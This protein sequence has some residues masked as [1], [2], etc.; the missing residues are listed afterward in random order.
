MKTHESISTVKLNTIFI[1]KNNI[2]FKL[3]FALA[4]VLAMAAS[5]NIFIYTAIS[6]VPITLQT[7]TVLLSGIFLG[8]RFA[9]MS[10]TA[11]LL[12]GI[13]GFPVFAGFRSGP[14]A[15]TGVTGGYLLGF[16]FAAYITGYIFENFENIVKE[17]TYLIIAACMS[18]LFIIYFLGY[19]HL[20]GLLYSGCRQAAFKT[21]AL[22]VFDIAVKPF[23]T[24][25]LIKLFIAVDSVLIWKANITK[26]VTKNH[27]KYIR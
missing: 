10:Q 5:A 19:V 7:I 6:P 23:V 18:G 22:R 13:I 27:K 26:N 25:E 15:I 17:K 2:V 11:Y 9:L 14:V 21:L 20:F 3:I 1:D 4:F 12:I 24:I 8:S 16:V